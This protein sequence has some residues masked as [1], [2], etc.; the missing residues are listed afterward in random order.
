MAWPLRSSR[1]QTGSPALTTA[2]S[3]LVVP[4]SIPIARPLHASFTRD[5]P[6]SAI[7]N[8]ASTMASTAL[9]PRRDRLVVDRHFVQETPVV[10]NG[11]QLLRCF[12]QGLGRRRA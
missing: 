7:W 5:C 3:E 8:R 1:R 10:T 11:D 4:R 12:R 6:G 9:G 2:T